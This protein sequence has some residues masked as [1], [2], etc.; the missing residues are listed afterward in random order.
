MMIWLVEK[1]SVNLKKVSISHDL[2]AASYGD[3]LIKL[4]M[5]LNFEEMD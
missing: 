2:K 1:L 4:T 5:R 3:P